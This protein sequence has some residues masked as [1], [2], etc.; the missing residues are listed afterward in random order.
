MAG[1]EGS[2]LPREKLEAGFGLAF[3]NG[4]RGQHSLGR[5]GVWTVLGWK[6]RQDRHLGRD[7]GMSHLQPLFIFFKIRKVLVGILGFLGWG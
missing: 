6:H 2:C 3:I 1:R 4:L 7:Q 5:R